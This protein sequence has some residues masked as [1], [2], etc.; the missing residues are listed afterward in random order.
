MNNP[1]EREAESSFP[2]ELQFDIYH[3]IYIM[4]YTRR[5]KHSL[6]KGAIERQVSSFHID[7]YQTGNG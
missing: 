5:R 6:S 1:N 4:I 2:R 7:S 3:I